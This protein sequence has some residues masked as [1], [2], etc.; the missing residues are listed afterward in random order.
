MEIYNTSDE[1]DY[2]IML[3]RTKMAERGLEPVGGNYFQEYEAKRYMEKKNNPCPYMNYYIYGYNRHDVKV[4]FKYVELNMERDT[5]NDSQR[6][7]GEAIIKATE[8]NT[9]YL[10]V[11]CERRTKS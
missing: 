3:N 10:T 8:A 11:G 6:L 9:L 4:Y 1:R 5:L 7:V 2:L